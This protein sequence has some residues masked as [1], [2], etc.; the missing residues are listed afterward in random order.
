MLTTPQP[1]PNG[2]VLF[3]YF[4]INLSFFWENWGGREKYINILFFL[5][6]VAKNID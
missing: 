3:L 4:N 5:F 2:G 6:L 1:R